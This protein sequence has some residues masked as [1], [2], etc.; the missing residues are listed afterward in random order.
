M[1]SSRLSPAKAALGGA[2]A[3]AIFSYTFW[4]LRWL[5]PKLPA[6]SIPLRRFSMLEA[7]GRVGTLGVTL[8]AMLSGYG[9]V[10]VPFSYISLFIR[11]VDRA[12]IAAMETQLKAAAESISQKRKNI[13]LLQQEVDVG[14]QAGIGGKGGA[15]SYF[16]RILSVVVPRAGRNPRQ[17][18]ANLETE[19]SSLE[20]LRDA[21]TTDVVELRRERDRALV[22]RTLFGH[23]Q[24][25]LGYVLSVYCL[26]RMFASTK[27]LVVGEDTSSDPVSRTLGFVLRIFS[28]GALILDVA[29][30]SQYLTL[31]FIGFISITSLRG[32]MKHMQRFFSMMSVLAGNSTG[33]VLLLTELLGCY[34]VSTLLLIRRQLPEKY[35]AAVTDAIG[36]ELEF[37]LYHRWFH[38]LFLVSAS[39][40]V[41]LFYQQVA[42]GRA[43]AMDKLPMYYHH[44]HEAKEKD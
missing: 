1:F 30:F 35:R 34:A 2:I 11:P 12:E 15:R 13:A 18:I 3:L 33:F 38:A 36:G 29:A 19:V 32:F 42:R 14:L 20:A 23:V 22:A 41:A 9:T 7:V 31:T 27:A 37:D 16:G 44:H 40:S 43:E 39:A 4:K 6:A 8:V 5:A 21:L 17:L 25:L 26:Y 28:G 10:S 24:N